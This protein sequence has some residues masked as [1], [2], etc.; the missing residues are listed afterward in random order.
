MAARERKPNETFKKYRENLTE[1]E[2]LMQ[3]KLRT[4][5]KVEHNAHPHGVRNIAAKH[6]PVQMAWIGKGVTFVRPRARESRTPAG[7]ASL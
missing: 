4:P 7:A 5:C 3:I 1:E 6:M 2:R